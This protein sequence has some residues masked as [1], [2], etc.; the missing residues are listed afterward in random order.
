MSTHWTKR[1]TYEEILAD[2]GKDYKVK[3]PGRAA[4]RS[5]H[6]AGGA[7]R[8]GARGGGRRGRRSGRWRAP[9]GPGAPSSPAGMGGRGGA[10]PRPASAPAIPLPEP[11]GKARPRVR[12]MARRL[13]GAGRCA[14][15]KRGTSVGSSCSSTATAISICRCLMKIE[16]F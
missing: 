8:H 3:L 13:A 2:L 5:G 10:P 6:A 9:A 1:P 12:R 4:V 16:M 15:V 11:S 7:A 14:Y